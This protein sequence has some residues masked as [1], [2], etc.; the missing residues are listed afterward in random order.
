MKFRTV[1][2][3]ADEDKKKIAPPVTQVAITATSITTPTK[4][5]GKRKAERYNQTYARLLVRRKWIGP[6][7]P[8]RIVQVWRIDDVV[9]FMKERAERG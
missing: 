4:S 6:E 3:L 1:T 9:S 2:T 8:E 5:G 7:A